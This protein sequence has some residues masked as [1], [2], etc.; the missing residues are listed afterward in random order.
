M[1]G[2][3]RWNVE[4]QEKQLHPHLAHV[5]SVHMLCV[6]LSSTPYFTVLAARQRLEKTTKIIFGAARSR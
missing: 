1:L 6:V 2:I 3:V 4:T 5:H